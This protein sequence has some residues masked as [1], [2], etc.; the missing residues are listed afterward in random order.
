[1][2][3]LFKT[4][5]IIA[6]FYLS[7][8]LFL[9]RDTFF[10]SNRWFLLLGLVTAFILPFMVIPIYVES[11]SID[12]SNYVFNT[13]VDSQ[14]AVKPF[15]VMTYLPVV[16]GLGVAFFSIRFIIQ[17]ISLAFVIIKNKSE[18]K[19]KFQYIKT[20]HNVSPFSF[21]NWI[22]YNPIQFSETELDQIITHEKVHVTDRHSFDIL[23]TQI[24]CIVLW[25]NPF[26]WFYNKDLKQNLE[27]I[28]DQETANKTECKKSYQYTL[29]KTSVPTHQMALSNNFYNSLIKKR[30]VMLHKSKSKKINQIKY[31]LVIPLLALFLMS[32]NTEKIYVNKNKSPLTEELLKNEVIEVIITKDFKDEDFENLKAKLKS[33]GYSA[34]FKKI[35]RNTKDEIIAIKI[36][37]TSKSANAHFNIDGDEAIE[38]VKITIEANG[39]NISIGNGN[40]Q[41]GKPMVFVTKDGDKHK[42]DQ[43]GSEKNV[44]VIK[45]GN[46]D[47]L[48]TTEEIIIKNGDTMHLVK[49]NIVHDVETVS[50]DDIIYIKKDSQDKKIH[51]IVKIKTNGK[52]DGINWISDDDDD[53][54]DDLIVIGKTDTKIKILSSDGEAPIMM[55]NGKEI[56]HEEMKKINPNTIDSMDVI[57]GEKA[58]L[59]YGDKGKNGVILISSKNENSSK[60]ALKMSGEALYKVDGKEVKKDVVDTLNPDDIESVNVLK[61]DAAIKKYGDKAKNGVIEITTKKKN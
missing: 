5:A 36:E 6:I 24:S 56:S 8:K 13:Q 46:N 48:F 4:S 19:G 58:T 16:Y 30:I 49:S 43:L 7:Y 25:F 21:F 14:N 47:D 34:T 27:F 61:G 18:I 37:V 52:E 57:K 1:M 2:E 59:K 50:Y 3:Y 39:K 40:F 22:V 38:P 9:E 31:A 41:K 28:A 29:L 35:K 20:T 23:L 44:F 55:L 15:D 33:E 10:E 42:K 17:F 26:M 54:D 60:Y 53:D 32:F 11:T 45:T 12:L 51:K